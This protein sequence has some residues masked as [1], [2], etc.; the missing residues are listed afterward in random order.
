MSPI[1]LTNIYKRGVNRCG[2]LAGDSSDPSH[3]CNFIFLLHAHR[4]IP[5]DRL[6][7]EKST[8]SF[9]WRSLVEFSGGHGLPPAASSDGG[10]R[11]ASWGRGGSWEQFPAHLLF[12]NALAPVSLPDAEG[13]ENVPLSSWPVPVGS[14][15]PSPAK[16]V[17]TGA[18]GLQGRVS[19]GTSMAD[20]V[21]SLDCAGPTKLN[22]ALRQVAPTCTQSATCTSAC[23]HKGTHTGVQGPF[24]T[25]GRLGTSE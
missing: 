23:T 6:R 4:H 13:T 9:P 24:Q 20:T 7:A 8:D 25:C 11:P 16:S 12:L 21:M 18:T 22:A 15:S 5:R 2:L 3:S 19:Q 14:F 1:G 10:R 17:F